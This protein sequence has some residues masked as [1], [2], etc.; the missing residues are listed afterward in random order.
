MEAVVFE[1]NNAEER[2]KQNV[3]DSPKSNLKE[4]GSAPNS[5]RYTLDIAV[6]S[7]NRLYHRQPPLFAKSSHTPSIFEVEST[8]IF[9]VEIKRKKR[10]ISDAQFLRFGS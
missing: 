4:A 9:E 7:L 1:M 2:I 8:E 3:I 10:G 6:L 5:V